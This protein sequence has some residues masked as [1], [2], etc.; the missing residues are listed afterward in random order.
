MH[1]SKL[2]YISTVVL[3]NFMSVRTEGG[4]DDGQ[5]SDSD[6]KR[7]PSENRRSLKSNITPEERRHLEE[8][9]ALARGQ[10]DAWKKGTPECQQHADA[11]LRSKKDG[12]ELPGV[13]SLKAANERMKVY[14]QAF[15]HRNSDNEEGVGTL[16]RAEDVFP[17]AGINTSDPNVMMRSACV[18]GITKRH[19]TQE[20]IKAC[21]SSY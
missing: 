3:L 13:L 7:Q 18:D 11:F 20:N 6:E 4:L 2:L 19:F 9:R 21:V 17:D 10:N 15:I 14:K 12:D 8:A 16:S 1:F 5:P